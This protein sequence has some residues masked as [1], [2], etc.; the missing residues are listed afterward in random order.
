MKITL[1]LQTHLIAWAFIKKRE[2][3][4]TA[5]LNAEQKQANQQKPFELD[6]ERTFEYPLSFEGFNGAVPN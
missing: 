4:D 3:F 2:I 1:S 5:Y 6:M